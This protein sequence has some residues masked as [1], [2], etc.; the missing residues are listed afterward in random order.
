MK[1]WVLT[2]IWIGFGR[3]F[4]RF[5]ISIYKSNYVYVGKYGRI[6]DTNK[7]DQS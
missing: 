7:I 4:A 6:S 1:E 3:E 5:I 2:R